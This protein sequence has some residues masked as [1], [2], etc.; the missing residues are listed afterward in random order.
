MNNV[1]KLI[2]VFLIAMA[3]GFGTV[4]LTKRS[5]GKDKQE[6][7]ITEKIETEVPPATNDEQKSSDEDGISEVIEVKEAPVAP[8]L[9]TNQT[10][11]ELYVGKSSYYYRVRGI[12]VSDESENIRFTLTDSF[13]HEYT[14]ENGKFDH[15]EANS[16]GTYTV[17]AHNASTGLSSE[18]VIIKGFQTIKPVANRL[19]TSELTS[20]IMTGDYDGSKSML[21]GKLAKHIS[22]KC[23]NSE[24]SYNTIQEVFISVG[25]ENWSVSVTSIDY[26]CLG[27]VT[28][29]KL[30]AQK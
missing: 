20:I 28:S 14:S 4:I 22:I 3:V 18:P 26:N 16:A 8:V 11:V 30:S 21:A 19:T 17:I 2:L 23:T 24:Y 13:G 5:S 29:I 25:L 1:F 10:K 12:K 9:V 7:Q 6:Y 27:Q 15:V